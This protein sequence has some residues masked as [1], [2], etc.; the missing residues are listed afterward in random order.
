LFL[1]V[2]AIWLPF[3][4]PLSHGGDQNRYMPMIDLVIAMNCQLPIVSEAVRFLTSVARTAYT[5]RAIQQDKVRRS[6]TLAANVVP[7]FT[8]S[9]EYINDHTLMF[10]LIASLAVYRGSVSTSGSQCSVSGSLMVRSPKPITNTYPETA[11]SLATAPYMGTL[12]KV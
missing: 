8:I 12:G 6:F 7:T 11:L 1:F 5:N 3:V 2:S 9:C 4:L 10:L